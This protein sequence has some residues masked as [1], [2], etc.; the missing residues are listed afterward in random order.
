[1]WQ[2]E[3]EGRTCLGIT[4]NPHPAA[5]SLSN[6]LDYRE[7]DASS[8]GFMLRAWG[9]VKTLKDAQPL[10]GRY[11]GPFVLHA[12]HN[13]GVDGHHTQRYRRCGAG[14]FCSVVKHL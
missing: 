2:C 1:M 14:I 10:L 13:L 12:K 7:A 8:R 5:V 4:F 11:K 9:A 3:K 6:P